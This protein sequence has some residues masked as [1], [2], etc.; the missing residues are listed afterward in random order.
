[1]LFRDIIGQKRIKQ[2]LRDTVNNKQLG[3]AWLFFGP[4]GSGTLQLANAFAGYILCLERNNSDSC[5]TCSSCLKNIKFIHPDVHFSFPVNK[6]K[7]VAK[8]NLVCDDF[9]ESW[10]S[11]LTD[12]PYGGLAQWYEMIGLENKQGI[13]STEESKRITYKL[14]LKPYESDYKISVI[15][16]AEKM[17]AQSANKLLKLIEEPHPN[18]IF[19][20]VSD[21]PD[22]ILPTVRSRCINIKVPRIEDHIIQD[23]LVA[24]HGKN[25]HEAA[26]I[27]RISDGSYLK[28]LS[29]IN[30]NNDSDFHF[31]KFRD[32][33]RV[34]YQKNVPEIMKLADELASL[35]REKQKFFIEYG[36]GIIRECMVLHYNNPE[37]IY[38][39][40]EQYEFASRFAPY[41]TD[42]N[43]MEFQE[44]LTKASRDIE[45]NAN[46]RIVF[47]DLALTITGLL[48]HT[49]VSRQ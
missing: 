46:G 47:L 27:A 4:E 1:M 13:I 18:T 12:E 19:I 9:L 44:E 24:Q 3:H 25:E 29:L 22:L 48:K 34:C 14:N 16:H 40:E 10:R 26:K 37:L 7:T 36:L 2:R 5:G 6:T 21:D 41:I 8:D 15:W 32:M 43:V 17:N 33:M 28:A 49:K 42:E 45:R 31:I 35:N 38:I 11:F 30:D 20:L 39:P 23:A